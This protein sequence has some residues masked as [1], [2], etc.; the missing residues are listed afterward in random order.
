MGDPRSWRSAVR[1]LEFMLP[2]SAPGHDYVVH[3]AEMPLPAYVKDLPF[4]AIV[5][6]PTF[7]CSRYDPRLFEQ[8][9]EDYAF[10]GDS[11]AFK[12]ALPQ[13]DYDCHAILDRW[14]VA[15]RID[16]VTSACP[17]ET[18]PVLYPSYSST[19]TIRAGYTGYVSDQWIDAWRTPRPFASRSID[20]SYRARKLPPNF[21]RI[22]H[23]KGVIGERF[24][25]QPA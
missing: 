12:I 18:W 11:T 6:G 4:D 1:D 14:M 10:I 24:A 13:D 25:A 2:A 9:S 3:A 16:A 19:G 22:G 20:V 17:V 8:V 23:L 7:L 21:G 5:L 15:W